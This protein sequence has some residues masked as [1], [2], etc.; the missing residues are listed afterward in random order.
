MVMGMATLE[1]P[2]QRSIVG[3]KMVTIRKYR[4]GDARS[5]SAL[6]SATY[7]RFN[8]HEGAKQ[9]VR[10]YVDSYNPRG[11]KAE[12][13]HNRFA[14]TPNCFVAITGSR[15][16]GVVRGIENRLI[17]LFV[18]GKFHRRG[19]ATRLLE[20]FEMVCR[21]SGFKEIVLRASLYATPFYKSAGYKKTTG[22][23]S[24][25]GLEFQPMKKELH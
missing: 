6:I 8:R 20:R 5:I 25:H 18:D 3:L 10:K 1:I 23:R 13:L 24:L 2:A 19:I 16:V 4:Q 15:I 21:K 11:K 17:N 22:V 14:R 12:D 9:A 7:L